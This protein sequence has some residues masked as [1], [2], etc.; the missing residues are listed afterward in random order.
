MSDRLHQL[1]FEYNP[2]EDRILMR[3]STQAGVGCRFWL[4]RRYTQLLW[5]AL[6]SGMDHQPDVVRQAA[7]QTREAVKAFQKETA[8]QSSNFSKKYQEQE[9]SFP[10][11][12]TPVLLTRVQTRIG[13]DKVLRL[14]LMDGDGRSITLNLDPKL[15]YSC[16]HLLRKTVAKADWGLTIEMPDDEPQ[17][18]IEPISAQVH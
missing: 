16:C 8:L 15:L 4:S 13:K 2:T 7:P 9:L 12:D 11:G 5:R 1:N 17:P 18:T 14:V 3:I 10:M 6:E